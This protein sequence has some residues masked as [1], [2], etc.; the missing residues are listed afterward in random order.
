MRCDE[1]S[2]C[3]AG[4]NPDEVGSRTGK[5]KKGGDRKQVNEALGVGENE[6]GIAA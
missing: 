4:E 2:E 6:D 1:R 3:R 5:E